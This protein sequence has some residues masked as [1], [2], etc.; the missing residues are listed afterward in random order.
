LKGKPANADKIIVKRTKEKNKKPKFRRQES[1]RQKRIR[2]NWRRPRGLD[3]KMR[4]RV[5]GWPS[6][7]R[8]G[9]RGPKVA[10]SLHPSGFR[11]VRVFNVDDLGHVD[12]QFEA[13]RVAHTVSVRKKTEIVNRAKEMGIHVLNPEKIEE[14][15][16]P[17]TEK[18]ESK[19]K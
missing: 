11:E 7:P 13:I 9:H 18:P 10:R 16:E 2:E 15:E 8:S 19:A 5:K 3:S 14:L 17:V 6:S 1:W 4:K 12:P